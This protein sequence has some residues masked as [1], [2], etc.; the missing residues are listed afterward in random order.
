MSLYKSV[1]AFC[2]QDCKYGATF[3]E[4]Q[5]FNLSADVLRD[6]SLKQQGS[7]DVLGRDTGARHVTLL[8][9]PTLTVWT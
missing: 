2:L 1:S 3:C 8:H 5:S 7:G 6:N 9:R 4:Q